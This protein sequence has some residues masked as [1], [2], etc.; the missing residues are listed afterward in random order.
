MCIRWLIV[1]PEYRSEGADSLQNR[2]NKVMIRYKK[3]HENGEGA[4]LNVLT[5]D[6]SDAPSLAICSHASGVLAA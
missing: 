2:G 5:F 4:M 1:L 6:R 3:F